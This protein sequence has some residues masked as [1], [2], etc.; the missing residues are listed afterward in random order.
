MSWSDN[1]NDNK[2]K[3]NKLKNEYKNLLDEVKL[4]I[5]WKNLQK[6]KNCIIV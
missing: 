6:M 2:L 1:R 5:Y 3:E 4:L